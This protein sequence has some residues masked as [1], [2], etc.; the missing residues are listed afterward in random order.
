MKKIKYG[1]IGERLGHSFSKEVHEAIMELNNIEGAPKYNY[2]ICE[3]Q[4]ED[5]AGFMRKRKFR[6]INVTIPYKESVIPY[7]KTVSEEAKLIGAVN[8]VVKRGLSLHGYNTDFAGMRALIQKLGIDPKGKK[9]VILGSGGTAKTAR[10]VLTHMG[11]DTI[12]TVGRQKKGGV[13]DYGEFHR[14][15]CD[16]Q[17]LVNTTPVGMYPHMDEMPVDISNL[18]DLCGVIDAVYNPLRTDLI[19]E[20]QKRGIPA[21]GGLYM[22]VAQAI[23][24]YEIFTGCKLPSEIFDKVY[25]RILTSKQN[26]VLIGMPA[27]GK[28][29]VGN[30]IRKALELPLCDT[31]EMVVSAR[32]KSIPDIFAE[33]GEKAF[34]DYE[35]TEIDNCSLLNGHIIATGGGSVLREKNIK[36]LKRNGRIYFIDRA[37]SELL[38]T[39][40]RPLSRTREHIEKLYDERYGIYCASADVHIQVSSD[41]KEAA[42]DIISDF[43]KK[44]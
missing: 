3:I 11:A 1:L 16:V 30:E 9:A 20:A 24:A 6:A 36:K 17:I 28:S 4:R 23:Y 2:E 40:D 35:S 32:Q 44:R 21:E 13:I 12:V 31:D 22:L 14:E 18:S 27:S 19:I 38:P 33:E 8:T 25:K 7:L 34:R 26:I 10:A 29:T 42:R 37:L 41:A 43:K 5:L 39:E 15:H